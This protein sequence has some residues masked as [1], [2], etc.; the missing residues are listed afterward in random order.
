MR[1]E[2]LQGL[3][4]FAHHH[5]GLAQGEAGVVGLGPLRPGGYRHT[6]LL[7]QLGQGGRLLV[8][9]GVPVARQGHLHGEG[10]GHGG[11][12]AVLFALELV[13]Q[14]LGVRQGLFEVAFAGRIVG[15]HQPGPAPLLAGLG[16][17]G[18]IAGFLRDS[19][20]RA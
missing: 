1:V 11:H 16:H 19:R 14:L 13:H 9:P 3:V 17:Q 5:L 4:H 7:F 12:A 8:G 10:R 15:H 6:G 20:A 18:W 2:D